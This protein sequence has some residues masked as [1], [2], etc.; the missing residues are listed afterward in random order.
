MAA[1]YELTESEPTAANIL[2]II[3]YVQVNKTLINLPLSNFHHWPWRRLILEITLII[4]SRS[5][6]LY[7][8]KS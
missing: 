1:G 8:Q 3:H 2:D 5:S 4:G 7:I 6:G